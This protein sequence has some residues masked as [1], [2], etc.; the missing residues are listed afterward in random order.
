MN[1]IV[2]IG[3]FSDGHIGSHFLEAA[4]S[5]KIEIFCI[6]SHVMYGRSLLQKLIWHLFDRKP[7]YLSRFLNEVELA[8]SDVSVRQLLV[9]GLIPLPSV[10]VARMRQLG[11]R[12][13]IYLT[14]DPFNRIHRSQRFLSSIPAYDVIFSP[15]RSILQDLRFIGSK[16]IE[17]LP[18]AY[19][20][21]THAWKTDD[22]T[23][24]PAADVMFVGGADIDRIPYATALM[25]AG[26][27]LALYGGYWERNLRLQS[28][29]RGLRSS[30]DI[31]CAARSAKI[32]VIL[33]R[34]ANRDGHVMR[35]FEAAMSKSCLLVEDTGE[36]REIFGDDG[37]CVIYFSSPQDL[38]D[39]TRTLIADDNRREILANRVF[40]RVANSN[41]STYASRL[42]FVREILDE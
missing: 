6:D 24:E 13:G 27:S 5:E 23:E 28:F 33:V 16:R 32:Q 40:E 14:D 37:D 21:L 31:R 26:F 36:H 34:R 38:V 15:R 17:L 2:I 19:D 25:D 11:I 39:R 1:K 20:P 10:F 29:A 12:C 42:R 18:F 8:V 30:A 4:R 3:N 35:T 7:M 22:K 9:V 41:D